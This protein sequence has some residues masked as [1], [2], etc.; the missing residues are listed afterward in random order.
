MI[1]YTDSD[2]TA[3]RYPRGTKLEIS[4]IDRVEGLNSQEKDHLLE[5]I[6]EEYAVKYFGLVKEESK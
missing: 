6:G 3:G 4:S 5:Q 1:V 2:Y